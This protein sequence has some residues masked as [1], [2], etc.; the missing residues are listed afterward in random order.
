MTA[1]KI[2]FLVLIG[3][4]LSLSGCIHYEP[5]SPF[6]QAYYPDVPTPWADLPPIFDAWTYDSRGYAN[7]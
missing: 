3:T 2:S 4:L 1:R 7:P 5:A 6:Y